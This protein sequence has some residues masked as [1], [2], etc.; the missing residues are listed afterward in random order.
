MSLIDSRR[1]AGQTS[2]TRT[3]EDVDESI[4]EETPMIDPEII[5]LGPSRRKGIVIIGSYKFQRSIQKMADKIVAQGFN[6]YQQKIGNNGIVRVGAQFAY[7]DTEDFNHKVKI[8][9]ESI[10]DRAWVLSH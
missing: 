10:E 4:L 1:N 9:R 2:T 8:I 7:E 5:E 3:S 6:V